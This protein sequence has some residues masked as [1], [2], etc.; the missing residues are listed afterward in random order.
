MTSQ[1]I[2][3]AKLLK[4]DARAGEKGAMNIRL[5]FQS[6]KLDRGLEMMVPCSQPIKL[7]LD[8]QHLV[9][10]YKSF[11]GREIYVPVALSGMDGNIF[12]RTTGD[13]KPLMLEEKKVAEQ[14]PVKTA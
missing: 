6:E 3:K 8:H 1:V 14:A 11:V 4:V 7:D 12:Y 9:E 13:G 2:F 10:L 5:I